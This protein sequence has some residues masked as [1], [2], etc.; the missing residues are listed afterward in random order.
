MMLSFWLSVSLIG[1]RNGAGFG[2]HESSLF[3]PLP[4]DSIHLTKPRNCST[5][6]CNVAARWW[7][8][9]CHLDGGSFC[10]LSVMLRRVG[11]TADMFYKSMQRDVSKST[12]LRHNNEPLVSFYDEVKLLRRG[13][14]AC[15]RN[16][17]Y[18]CNNT[19]ETS[20]LQVILCCVKTYSFSKQAPRLQSYVSCFYGVIDEVSR[21]K[22][23]NRDD[24]DREWRD[25]RWIVGWGQ[26][27]RFY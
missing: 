14:D 1:V 24:I 26:K 6:I 3:L 7:M 20:R 8:S 12:Q 18:Y 11:V 17:A 16:E 19:S 25:Q 22:L 15:C 9:Q 4:P 13:M 27:Y 2:S 21:W 10:K 23:G 5:V